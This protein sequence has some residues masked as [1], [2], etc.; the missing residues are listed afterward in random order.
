MHP[1]ASI[2]FFTTLSGLG[3]G[4]AAWL[5]LGVMEP[6]LYSTLAAYA[7]ALALIGAGLLSSTLAPG[8]SAAR[9]AGVFAMAVELAVA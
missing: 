2:I 3:Y 6:G 4:L 5:G 1:A 9:M 8:Q 7:L